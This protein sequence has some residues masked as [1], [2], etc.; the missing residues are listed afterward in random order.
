M[1]AVTYLGQSGPNLLV[2]LWLMILVDQPQEGQA[3]E[4]VLLGCCHGT[5][6]RQWFTQ[7]W[8]VVVYGS[9]GGGPKIKGKKFYCRVLVAACVWCMLATW[10]LI[11]M[12]AMGL[13]ST[14]RGRA[15]R[16]LHAMTASVLCVMVAGMP[17]E[18]AASV[19][20]VMQPACC[21]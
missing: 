18:M 6:W 17:C 19:L 4:L 15:A 10:E 5:G 8:L 13:V 14:S 7:T 20:S 11:V 3:V 9:Q 12:A 2:E 1:K 21:E 16:V